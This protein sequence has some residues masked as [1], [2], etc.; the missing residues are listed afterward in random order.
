M[1]LTDTQV[2]TSKSAS[3][4][5][6][7]KDLQ[8]HLKQAEAKQTVAPQIDPLVDRLNDK[9]IQY[10]LFLLLIKSKA[11]ENED[12]R[13][14]LTHVLD[15][16]VSRAIINLNNNFII[17]FKND[18]EAKNE[19]IKFF[20]ANPD[21]FP[22]ILFE[23][24]KNSNKHGSDFQKGL[25]IA[26]KAFR[27]C[28]LEGVNLEVLKKFQPWHARWKKDKEIFA[29][30]CSA[31]DNYLN[32]NCRLLLIALMQDGQSTKKWFDLHENTFS[33]RLAEFNAD[34][35]NLP[36][37][38]Q[39]EL[40]IAICGAEKDP[41]LRQGESL[42]L[43]QL[44]L[45]EPSV[46]VFLKKH[47]EIIEKAG[48]VWNQHESLQLLRRLNH[49]PLGKIFANIFDQ[50]KA[51]SKDGSFWKWVNNR[52]NPRVAQIFILI[53]ASI[54]DLLKNH[55]KLRDDFAQ[56]IKSEE[57]PAN[58]LDERIEAKDLN[59]KSKKDVAEA[60][61]LLAG[62]FC[63]LIEE[64]T[65]WH[66]LVALA[67]TASEWELEPEADRLARKFLDQKY[68][69]LLMAGFDKTEMDRL[70]LWLKNIEPEGGRF[71]DFLTK[72]RSFFNKPD[73][74]QLSKDYRTGMLLEE[75]GL[76]LL[77][78]IMIENRDIREFF[79]ASSNQEVLAMVNESWNKWAQKNPVKKEAREES[80]P[81]KLLEHQQNSLKV[82]EKLLLTEEIISSDYKS[83]KRTNLQLKRFPYISYLLNILEGSGNYLSDFSRG[84]NRL[85]KA[86]GSQVRNEFFTK[87]ATIAP[88]S[89]SKQSPDL[90]GVLHFFST[91]PQLLDFLSENITNLK[92]AVELW[93]ANLSAPPVKE[94]AP[95]KRVMEVQLATIPEEPELEVAKRPSV[96]KEP[97]V[98]AQIKQP[99]I[100]L[101]YSSL[102]TTTEKILRQL[103]LDLMTSHSDLLV[104]SRVQTNKIADKPAQSKPF[105]RH[106]FSAI[107][108]FFAILVGNTQPQVSTAG[109]NAS[110][111]PE[112]TSLK[113][114]TKAPEKSSKAIRAFPIPLCSVSSN[115]QKDQP[116]QDQPPLDPTKALCRPF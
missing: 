21:A 12:I 44:Y 31:L 27:A 16:E 82:I 61:N 96:K 75:E 56:V 22:G 104:S 8:A 85:L 6:L 9:A 26:E 63:N 24:T 29:N 43:K 46:R 18:S 40:L 20:E 106:I 11:D 72:M 109:Q 84:F 53:E 55:H 4:K 65:H 33:K 25:E 64:S 99:T 2:S 42:P 76:F 95:P 108:N 67:Q 101:R 38:V 88:Y 36:L 59:L 35:R 74:E 113:V 81:Y 39:N 23:P 30:E 62:V 102:S 93:Q 79:A 3:T 90:G 78:K 70:N 32:N 115:K 92:E 47:H 73:A 103:A 49:A 52:D 66:D 17:R 15:S 60:R 80:R 69:A 57:F 86:L 83:K 97:V 77:K 41:G 68:K 87:L 19:L 91:Q 50:H 112:A 13:Y 51:F 116:L 58:V 110:S 107:A 7:P 89:N 94:K 5:S 34:Y 10:F 48:S 71:T 54:A 114:T 111:H 100:D 105:W 98:T 45:A 37:K 1:A 14:W 28:Q